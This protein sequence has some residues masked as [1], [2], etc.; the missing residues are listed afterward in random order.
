MLFKKY[1]RKEGEKKRKGINKMKCYNTE[2]KHKTQLI[3]SRFNI[4][5]MY[6]RVFSRVKVKA[7]YC[8]GRY[9]D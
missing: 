5:P 7:G 6:Q 9:F 1:K 2:S 4:I 3:E 8:Y